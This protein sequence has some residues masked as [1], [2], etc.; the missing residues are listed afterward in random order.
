MQ[1]QIRVETH[2]T[3][4][5]LRTPKIGATSRHMESLQL[6]TQCGCI[7]QGVTV[8]VSESFMHAGPTVAVRVLRKS[9]VYLTACCPHGRPHHHSTLP[10]DHS[11]SLAAVSAS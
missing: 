9:L 6:H 2:A 10:H 3:D 7:M 4:C 8:N 1:P 11:T 5:E